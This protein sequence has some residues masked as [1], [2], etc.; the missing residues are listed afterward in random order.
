MKFPYQLKCYKV[1]LDLHKA[2]HLIFIMG[3]VNEEEH[4]F[5]SYNYQYKKK[6]VPLGRTQ[7]RRNE[8]NSA[9][10]DLIVQYCPE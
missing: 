1:L 3:N 8:D 10:I 9:N 4:I 5:V 2:S 7:D 6:Y